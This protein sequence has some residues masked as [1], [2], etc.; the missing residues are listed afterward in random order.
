MAS[1]PGLPQ[2]RLPDNA[3]PP[4]APPQPGPRAPVAFAPLKNRR[5]FEEICDRI[6]QEL[7]VGTLGPGD[8]LPAERELSKQFGASR[9][10]VREALRSLEI[11][12]IVE[13]RKGVKGGAFIRTGDPA[14]VTGMMQDMVSLGRVSLDSLTEARL[15]IQE[16]VVRLAA[17][18]A[19]EE[20]FALIEDNIRQAEALTAAGSY[21]ERLHAFADFYI[22]ICRATRN[23]VLSF[24]TDALT[25]VV[26]SV[27]MR[28]MPNPRMDTLA[29]QRELLGLL[30]AR[31]PDGAAAV[32]SEH[33]RIL[34]RHLARWEQRRRAVEGEAPSE[35]QPE[36]AARAASSTAKRAAP[37]TMSSTAPGSRGS[38]SP[39][40][41][42]MPSGR[43]S[44]R[45]RS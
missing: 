22:L 5:V 41:T 34:H 20:D 40:Q 29:F 23:E 6:R 3:G 19:T 44:T 31:D 42:T 15:L 37:R 32:M 28:V 10:A 39:R 11:A 12:G 16:A 24:V 43:T 26:R 45:R 18:R 7:N 35:P 1:R 36:A 21:N 4:A 2:A 38:S 8:K 30:R 27:L 25:G 14:M 17:Q 33:L 13:L 9:S